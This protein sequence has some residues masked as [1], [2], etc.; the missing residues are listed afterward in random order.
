MNRLLPLRKHLARLVR[1]S[2][3]RGRGHIQRLSTRVPVRVGFDMLEDRCLLSGGPVITEFPITGYPPSG[4]LAT[5]KLEDWIDCAIRSD[6]RPSVL[7]SLTIL[8]KKR[9]LRD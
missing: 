3:S 7:P 6:W 4:L 9:D 1:E 8:L 2:I 5:T